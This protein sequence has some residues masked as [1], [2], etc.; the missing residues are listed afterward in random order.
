M[1]ISWKYLFAF[2]IAV[3]AISIASYRSGF[4][5]GS[6]VALCLVSTFQK[7]VQKEG[8]DMSAPSCRAAKQGENNPLWIARKRHGNIQ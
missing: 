1:K 6:S 2:F 4:D 5:Q 8:L 7:G 3:M